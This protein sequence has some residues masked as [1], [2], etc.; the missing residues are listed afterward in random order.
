[1][2]GIELAQSLVA[3]RPELK[4][5]FTSGYTDEPPPRSELDRTGAGFLQ[6]PF[7]ADALL[8]K[9]RESARRPPSVK[10]PDP[11]NGFSFALSRQP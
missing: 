10:T 3:Q 1:M 11:A 6:K 8:R 9:V 4:V 2:S 7:R 5:L